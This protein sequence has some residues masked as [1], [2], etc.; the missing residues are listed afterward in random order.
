[1]PID[2][3]VAKERIWKE[4]CEKMVMQSVRFQKDGRSHAEFTMNPYHL[5]HNKPVTEPVSTRARDF[6]DRPKA[7]LEALSARLA[8]SG[9]DPNSGKQPSFAESSPRNVAHI[10]K[11]RAVKGNNIFGTGSASAESKKKLLEE[12]S[13]VLNQE[14]GGV[15]S[16]REGTGSFLPPISNSRQTTP[17]F[18]AK[19]TGA[20]SP[21]S[22]NKIVA[23]P[24]ASPQKADF[25]GSN[26]VNSSPGK[27]A[28]DDVVQ[29]LLLRSTKPPTA[30]YTKPQ[31][32]AQVLGW[33]AQR[34]LKANPMFTFL[35]KSC[36]M[37][38]FA[39]ESG[40]SPTKKSA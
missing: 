3:E 8:A 23:S 18:Y 4:H 39:A 28:R 37:T 15:K 20:P 25:S 24:T 34:A 30:K 35:H 12:W 40:H 21:L 31:T 19:G 6:L 22:P 11:S 1:M 38:R 14:I 26:T 29:E 9:L 7:T 5:H 13:E 36:D 17:N 27:S 32:E 2:S 10:N 16:F 33:D